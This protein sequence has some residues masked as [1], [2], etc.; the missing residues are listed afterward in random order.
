MPTPPRSEQELDELLSEPREATV[1]ALERAPGDIVVLGA[2]GKMGPTLAR[3]AVRAA[4]RSGTSARRRVIAVSR[5]SSGGVDRALQ[6]AGVETIRCD[7]LDRDAVTALGERLAAE[8]GE[9]GML[10]NNAGALSR[11]TIE[12]VDLDELERVVRLNYLAGV[13]MTRSV[14]PAL[15]RAGTKGGAHIV[16]VT[17]I[18]GV[19]AFPPGAA[20]SA[21]KHAQTAFSRSLS[22][23]LRTTG[24]RVHMVM[25]GFVVTQGF[26]HPRFWESRL[27]RRFVVGP[28][29]VATAIVAA[30]EKG[31]DE[32]VVPWFPYGLASVAQA[33]F[34]TLTARVMALDAYRDKR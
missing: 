33:L 8:H 29:R 15:L 30:V 26:P 6:D 19:I 12:Q 24:V 2:G 20:Y 13:W 27:G 18:S 11:G 23:A 5:F 3:M 21:S 32:V 17:S 9:I 25:P 22:A 14:L 16:N 7:L 31:R 1:A 28:D 10:V 34:P 4:V